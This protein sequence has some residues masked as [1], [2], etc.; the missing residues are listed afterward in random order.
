MRYD[1]KEFSNCLGTLNLAPEVRGNHQ[2]KQHNT[3]EFEALWFDA[4]TDLNQGVS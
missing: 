2:E 4:I 3:H 1:E